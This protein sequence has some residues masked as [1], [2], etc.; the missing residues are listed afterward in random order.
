MIQRSDPWHSRSTLSKLA[1]VFERLGLALI[2]AS[3]GLFV[4]AAVAVISLI[5]SSEAL[6]AMMLY[7]ATAFYLGIDL[8]KA[9]PGHSSLLRGLGTSQDMLELLKGTGIFLTAMTAVVSVF[10]IILGE[11]PAPSAAGVICFGWAIGATMQI[12]AG[13]IARIKLG[14]AVRAA[15]QALFFQ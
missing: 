13:V 1:H 9:A 2:G 7:G 3:T 6:V 10:S 15:K 5:G 4:A 11:A 8:P 14:R 12:A